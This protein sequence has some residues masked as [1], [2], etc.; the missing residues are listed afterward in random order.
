MTGTNGKTTTIN[1]INHIL[2]D[3][4]FISKLG[5]NVGIPFSINVLDEL[6][7]KYNERIY[8]VLELSSFQLED[9]KYFK[10]DI[11]IILNISPDHLDH[12]KNFNNY[13]NSKIRIS[14]NQDKK[15]YAIFNDNNLLDIHSNS[16]AKKLGLKLAMIMNFL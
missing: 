1:L 10:P 7:N 4:N 8:H 16:K 9:I 2:S 13:L 5:G 14:M 6:K 12:H 11:S 3:N 15:G